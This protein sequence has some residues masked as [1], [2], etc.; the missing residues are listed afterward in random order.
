MM[1]VRIDSLL[2]PDFVNDL[3]K[4]VPPI[5]LWISNHRYLDLRDPNHFK[6]AFCLSY[7]RQ[8]ASY[9]HILAAGNALRHAD[10]VSL[11]LEYLLDR[12]HLFDMWSFWRLI[13]FQVFSLFRTGPES[14]VCINVILLPS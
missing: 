13:V 3:K 10:L 1:T 11:D 12:D 7:V 9:L 5:R 4:P 6:L 8:L 14:V 2:L